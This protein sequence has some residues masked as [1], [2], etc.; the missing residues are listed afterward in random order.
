MTNKFGLS[1]DIPDAI[2]RAVRQRCGFG[3]V[4]CASAIIDYEHFDPVFS[5]AR[6]HD[7]AGITLLCPGCHAKKTRNMLSVRRV[8]EANAQPAA[9]SKRYSYAEV[10]GTLNRP[11]IK[12]GGLMLRNCTTPLLLRG[13]PV[14]Q[15]EDAEGE[16]S[17]FTL[18]ASFFSKDGRPSLFVRRNEWQV[19]SGTWDVEVVGPSV[20]VRTGR[21]EIALGLRFVPGEGLVVERLEMFCAGFSI[22]G[23][24]D[25][26][27][28]ETP[29]GI[30]L[31]FKDCSVDG[32]TIGLQLD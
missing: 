9:L 8:R 26:L 25:T 23:N 31:N 12:L 24:A 7:A 14:L 2:K 28:I 20:T 22:D 17:P 27:R 1:R 32:A 15:V 18:S 6:Q 3:C 11:F 4:I 16:S 30:K 29:Q 13:F 5:N 19:L 10:E 21:G